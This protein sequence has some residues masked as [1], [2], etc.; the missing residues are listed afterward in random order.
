M[1]VADSGFEFKASA[2][3]LVHWP[4]AQSPGTNLYVVKIAVEWVAVRVTLLPSNLSTTRKPCSWAS[5]QHNT[6]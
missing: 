3:L 6:S 2:A 4:L 1:H 5:K